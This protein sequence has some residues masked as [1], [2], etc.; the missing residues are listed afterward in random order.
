LYKEVRKI[1]P[2]RRRAGE[3]ELIC[4]SRFIGNSKINWNA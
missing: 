3:K 4:S 2:R 1:H